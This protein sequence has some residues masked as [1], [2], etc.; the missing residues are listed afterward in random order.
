MLFS[1]GILCGQGAC[2]ESGFS[3]GEGPK[4]TASGGEVLEIEGLKSQALGDVVNLKEGPLA[5]E[6]DS[7]ST[8]KQKGEKGTRPLHVVFALDVTAS[9]GASLSAVKEGL[10][11][12]VEELRDRDFDTKVGFVAFRD[13][14]AGSL[15]LTSDIGSFLT[16]FSELAD[17]GG[18]DA[19]EAALLAVRDSLSL[20]VAQ[21]E[22]EAL[23]VVMVVTDN[24]GHQGG[25]DS[26]GGPLS[27]RDCGIDPLVED[28]ESLGEALSR[29]RLFDSTPGDSLFQIPCGGYDTS[30]EQW[31]DVRDSLG[32]DLE[33]GRSFSFPLTP[34]NLIDEFVEEIE[35]SGDPINSDCIPLKATLAKGSDSLAT[36]KA[37]G[38]LSELFETYRDT[39]DPIR[40]EDALSEADIED[41]D[42][43]DSLTLTIER[44]CVNREIKAAAIDSCERE[45]KQ[46]V[47]FDIRR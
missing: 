44:C 10:R 33:L 29:F 4:K 9:M 6:F 42:Q 35:L 39:K 47:D 36:W 1:L 30:R 27:D 20:L 17:F 46:V 26:S 43:K 21:E 32:S 14:I 24:V 12:F 34:E 28:L 31:A 16:D 7:L 40:W 18:S 19:H 45:V 13:S 22:E 25:G 38:E 23:Q 11:E 41:L 37:K 15:S 5:I 3:S 2:S 8:K